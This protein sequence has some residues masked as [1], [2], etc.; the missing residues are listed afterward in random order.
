MTKKKLSHMP[1]VE[2]KEILKCPW[3]WDVRLRMD[4]NTY[5]RMTVDALKST[6]LTYQITVDKLIR[7][8]EGYFVPK[9]PIFY[10]MPPEEN[11]KEL[12]YFCHAYPAAVCCRDPLTYNKVAVCDDCFDVFRQ[13]IFELVDMAVSLQVLQDESDRPEDE[14]RMDVEP[15][16]TSKVSLLLQGF[17]GMLDTI[18]VIDP[19]RRKKE[20]V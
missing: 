16:I 15:D 2:Y 18:G 12:C 14:K 8:Y 1:N 20:E 7:M 10:V 13:A 5:R 9:T 4:D 11:D 3:L 6:A 19:L 17:V